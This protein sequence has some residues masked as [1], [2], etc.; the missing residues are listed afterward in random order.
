VNNGADDNDEAL[1]VKGK[2]GSLNGRHAA[3]GKQK[4]VDVLITG[5]WAQASPSGGMALS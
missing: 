5:N 1:A 4:T 2:K 3:P